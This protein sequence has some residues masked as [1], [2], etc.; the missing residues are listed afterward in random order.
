MVVRDW[1]ADPPSTQWFSGSYSGV[2][3]AACVTWTD[4]ICAVVSRNHKHLSLL[5]PSPNEM[6]ET[7]EFWL[8]RPEI[9]EARVVRG[10]V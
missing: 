1:S 6:A 8:G 7:L 3:C 5:H 10:G 9:V 4:C 2:V